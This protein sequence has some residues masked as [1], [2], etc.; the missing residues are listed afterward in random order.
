MAAPLVLIE[1]FDSGTASTCL[2]E[3]AYSSVVQFPAGRNSGMSL[4]VP[5]VSLGSVGG[6]IARRSFTSADNVIS[7]GVAIKIQDP[8][9]GA[10]PFFGV[11]DTG[12]SHLLDIAGGATA[13]YVY[14]YTGGTTQFSTQFNVTPATNTWGYLELKFTYG[15]SGYI[16]ARWNGVSVLS[17]TGANNRTNASTGVIG[18]LSFGYT[19]SSSYCPSYFD[20]LWVESGTGSDF[21]GDRRVITLLPTSD[22]NAGWDSSTGANHWGEVDDVTY[23]TY[24]H[25]PVGTGAVDTYG[26]GDMPAGTFNIDAVSVKAVANT[27]YAP[28]NIALHRG[29]AAGTAKQ[30]TTSA[31]LV[32]QVFASDASSVPWTTATVNSSSFGIVAAP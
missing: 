27:D 22:V 18:G 20:D 2:T 14:Y 32:S 28:A 23:S 4:Y 17:R 9:S 6:D 12:G 1:G 7:L 24:V 25:T 29:G 5:G 13:W 19:G 26:F 30:V 21:R 3:W 16:E 10:Y 11:I 15:S 8:Q 31:R